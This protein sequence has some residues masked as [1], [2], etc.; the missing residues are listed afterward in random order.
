M[1]NYKEDTDQTYRT[2][3]F[4]ILFTVFAIAATIK[5][6]CQSSYSL[7]SSSQNELA[8]G[9]SPRRVDAI[10]F[11]AIP[12]P[13]IIKT[14]DCTLHNTNLNLFD[15]QYK[16]SDYNRR[17]TQNIILLQKTR[18]SIIPVPLWRFCFHLPSGEN[19]DLPVLS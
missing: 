15:L 6:N 18:L 9:N 7:P 17:I 13:F 19:E 11:D 3:L 16:I 5:S 12:L 14:S 10:I 4:I 8:F 1:G 2:I